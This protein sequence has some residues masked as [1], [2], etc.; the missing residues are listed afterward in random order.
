MDLSY[1][2]PANEPAL[3]PVPLEFRATASE[4]FRIWAVNT[5][6]TIATL[7]IYSA[8]AK[9]RTRRYMLGNTLLAGSSFDFHADPVKILKGRLIMGV[10]FLAYAFGSTISPILPIAAVVIFLVLLPWIIVRSMAF[11]LG[12]TSYRNL[13]FGF[14]LDYRGSYANYGKS[15]LAMLLTLGIATPWAMFRH[16]RFRISHSRFGRTPFDYHG[17]AGPFWGIYILSFFLYLGTALVGGVIMAVFT[18]LAPAVGAVLGVVVIYA[19]IFIAAA[20]VRA[21]TF[22]EVASATTI[23]K[24][25]FSGS[26]ETTELAWIYLSNLVACICTLGLLIPWAVVRTARYKIQRTK[27][28]AAPGALDAFVAAESSSAG[29]VADAA[30]DFL[31]IDLGF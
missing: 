18:K 3:E 19:G 29:V 25:R 9:V 12:N 31:D 4:Y 20:H 27:V 7:G 30:T 8:W 28:E 24:I 13:R 21:R 15:Y 16:H 2:D 22:N 23:Q 14:Q 10:L 17:E 1:A 6:L 26:L 11:N 5:L